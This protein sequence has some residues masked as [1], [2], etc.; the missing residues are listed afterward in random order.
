MV[1]LAITVGL[2]PAVSG[3]FPDSSTLKN[4]PQAMV[5]KRIPNP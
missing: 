2:Q 5:A 4:T 3:S 1:K